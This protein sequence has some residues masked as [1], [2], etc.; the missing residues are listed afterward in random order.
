MTQIST[1]T[2]TC[3]CSN[4]LH[5]PVLS[6]TNQ[7]LQLYAFWQFLM[8]VCCLY[9][10]ISQ[11]AQSCTLVWCGLYYCDTFD[12][13]CE[14]IQ[15]VCIQDNKEVHEK[16]NIQSKSLKGYSGSGTAM[17]HDSCVKFRCVRSIF[18]HGMQFTKIVRTLQ[19]HAMV[20]TSNNPFYLCVA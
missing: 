6:K 3:A 8:S 13:S 7:F 11:N 16:Y 1:M 4:T 5:F 17:V 10:Y 12:A 9:C 14:S 18:K 15:L 2:W 19:T 20:R